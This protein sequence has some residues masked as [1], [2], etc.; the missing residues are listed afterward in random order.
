MA[1]CTASPASQL[2]QSVSRGCTAAV[3]GQVIQHPQSVLGG[4]TAIV[5]ASL[6]AM[7]SVRSCSWAALPA[8]LA[9]QLPQCVPWGCAVAVG[10]QVIQLPQSVPPGC[11][12]IVG[13]S[14]LA[15]VSV[16]S[17][18]WAALPASLA[19]QLPQCVPWGST[20][21]VGG[22]VIQHPQSVLGGCTAIVG[23]SLL[24]MVSV[25]SS[26]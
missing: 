26:C 18:S 8:S 10:D 9:S 11:T 14:L 12:A 2:P 15:M 22:Q 6:L 21:A 20:A 25:R 1:A 16:R 5:G 17:C 4:C 19:S 13:A 23:A 24:A 7:V 3:G